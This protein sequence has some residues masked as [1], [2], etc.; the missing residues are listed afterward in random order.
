VLGEVDAPRGSLVGATYH[1]PD[2]ET[3]YCDNTEVASARISGP[4]PPLARSLRLGPARPRW[5]PTA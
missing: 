4:R 5:W 1:D 2:G 3:A